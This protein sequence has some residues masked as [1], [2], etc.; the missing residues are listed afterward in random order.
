MADI[1]PASHRDLLDSRALA[2]LATINADG[3]PQVTP[4][5]F[6]FESGCVVINSAKGRFKDNN[7]RR[8]S[9]V[10]LSMTDPEN[11]YRYLE[12]RGRVIEIT[13][14]GADAKIDEL[15]NKYLGEI[16]P[17]RVDGEIRVT[18]MIEPTGIS[19]MG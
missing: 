15:S 18:Y 5:W 6:G 14:D 16:Y 4:V 13:E 7:M 10:S 2:H 3:S 12:V 19:K 8:D 17:H 9:R 11:P 1:I